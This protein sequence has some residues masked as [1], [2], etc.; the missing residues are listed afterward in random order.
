M[1]HSLYHLGSCR[2][3]SVP[4]RGAEKLGEGSTAHHSVGSNFL[5]CGSVK[6]VGG[7]HATVSR[8]AHKRNH[9]GV[10][11]TADND[12]LNLGTVSSE[13]VGEEIFETCAV[14]CAAHADDTVLGETADLVDQIGH[15]VHRVGDADDHC[16]GRVLEQLLGHALHDAGINT[17]KLLA[18]HAGLAGDA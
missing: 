3:W 18:G 11:V 4:C 16:I 7:G 14:E 2:T 1:E 5:K 9:C 12:T 13:S 17:D 10:A 8:I 15:S 6:V